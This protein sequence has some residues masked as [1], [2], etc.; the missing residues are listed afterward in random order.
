MTRTG[1]FPT[2]KIAIVPHPISLSFNPDFSVGRIKST[3]ISEAATTPTIPLA[4]EAK[5]TM[6]A[7]SASPSRWIL[8]RWGNTA[9]A[10]E[11]QDLADEQSNQRMIKFIS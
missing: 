2:H 3:A 5:N 10:K 4:S 9:D 1:S 8:N 7:A 6:T 11:D